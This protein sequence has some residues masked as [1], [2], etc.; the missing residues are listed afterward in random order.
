MNVT[1]K[2]NVGDKVVT[3]E[4]NTMRVKEFEVASISIYVPQDETTR[5]MYKPK[6]DVYTSDSYDETLCFAA[7]HEL[8]DYIS[9][10]DD[11]AAE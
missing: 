2:F 1:T 6:S 9:R 7:R 8:I 4:K 10:P 5:V 3:I 11:T